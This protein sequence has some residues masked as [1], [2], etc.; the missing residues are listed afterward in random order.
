M[1][2]P[3]QNINGSFPIIVEKNGDIYETEEFKNIKKQLLKIKDLRLVVFDPLSSFINGDIT[4]NSSASAFLTGSLSKLA[5][6]TK[7]SVLITHHLRKT[8]GEI[9]GVEDIR[10]AIRGS[11]ALVNGVRLAYAFWPFRKNKQE[12]FF[13][14]KEKAFAPNSLY[15][16][17][18]VKANSKVD[19]K[20]KTYL[21]NEETGLLRTIEHKKKQHLR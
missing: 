7:A 4:F 17:A 20:I 12:E 2:I 10:D 14:S 8:N 18:V 16:G 6:D 9:N 1:I 15:N 5:V 19:R 21:R 11:S 13:K 3:L